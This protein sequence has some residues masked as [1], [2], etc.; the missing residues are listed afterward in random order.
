M[1]KITIRENR[2]ELYGSKAYVSLIKTEEMKVSNTPH[3]PHLLRPLDQD[4]SLPD[5]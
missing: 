3:R 4:L 5:I 1:W 2:L